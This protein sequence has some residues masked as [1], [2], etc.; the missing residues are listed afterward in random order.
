MANDENQS[1][2]S[3]ASFSL[4]RKENFYET[5]NNTTK[6]MVGGCFIASY[7]TEMGDY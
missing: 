7:D 2:K 6:K 4:Y 5:E 1:I 3:E